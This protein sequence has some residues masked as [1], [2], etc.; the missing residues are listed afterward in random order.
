MDRRRE[1]RLF[2][3]VSGSYRDGAGEPLE[4]TFGQIS[5]S[6]CRLKHVAAHLAVGDTIELSLG[7][8]GPVN[9]TIRWRRDDL[10]GVEFREPLEAA[11]VA[12]FAAHCGAAA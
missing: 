7:P 1:S 9:A 6:G 4:I 3:E 10:A 11:I 5:V 8:I 12:F 2:V